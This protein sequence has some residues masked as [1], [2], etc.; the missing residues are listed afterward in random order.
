VTMGWTAHRLLAAGKKEEALRVYRSALELASKAD[1]A[2]LASP[3]FIDDAQ[4]RRYA[5]PGE[6]LIGP[7][8]RDLAE[9]EGWTYAE[10]SEALPAFAV[11]PLAAARVLRERSSPDASAPLD[12]ILAGADAPTP[13]GV[14]AAVH[15]AAQAEA[16]ALKARWDEAEQRYRQAIELMPELSIRRSWWMNLAEIALRLNNESSRQ[17]ALEAARGTDL[18]D[19]I[20]RRAAEILKPY[21]VRGEPIN[22]RD[23]TASR[24]H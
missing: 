2:R 16:F 23:I 10:W 14:S 11:A 7:L 1:P 4:I 22:T 18:D 19:E 3:A 24:L 5:L 12:T 8:V 6:D 15:L 13:D 17:K 21:H 20:T 9:H